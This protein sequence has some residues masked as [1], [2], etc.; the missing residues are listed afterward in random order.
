MTPFALRAAVAEA[1]YRVT[2]A[3]AATLEAEHTTR[4][5]A[6]YAAPL[7][8]SPV[9]GWWRVRVLAVGDGFEMYFNRADELVGALS[10]IRSPEVPS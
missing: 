1:G 2:H 9:P 4:C 10:R 8:L 5:A 6:L 3:D 7:D